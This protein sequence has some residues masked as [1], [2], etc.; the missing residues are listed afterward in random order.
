MLVLFL[1]CKNANE[2]LIIKGFFVQNGENRKNTEKVLTF[3]RKVV[4]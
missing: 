2:P 3:P 1:L 4:E